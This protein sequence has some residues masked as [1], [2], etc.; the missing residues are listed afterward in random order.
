MQIVFK[1]TLFFV[2][3]GLLPLACG[4][5][6]E[7][8]DDAGVDAGEDCEPDSG[9]CDH[10]CN[11]VTGNCWSECNPLNDCCES[12]GTVCAYGCDEGGAEYPAGTCWPECDPALDSCC[13]SNG[14]P[15]VSGCKMD[16][17]C[18][19]PM[20]DCTGGKFDPDNNLC[21]QDPPAD[22]AMNWYVAAGVYSRVMIK[23]FK[24]V[25]P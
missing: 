12:N 4:D 11:T 24:K 8:D 18:Y 1:F 7:S 2:L 13:E 3:I 10:G 19:L 23:P 15:C 22:I 25:L 21:W 9:L 5:D 14:L 16:G 6:S 17:A 20:T